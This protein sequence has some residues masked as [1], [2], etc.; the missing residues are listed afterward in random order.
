S[1]RV[2]RERIGRLASGLAELGV[3]PGD[4]V[5]VLDWD[6]HRYLEC[7]FAVPMLGA[8]LHTVNIRLA[9]SQMVYTMNHAEDTVVLVHE[10]FLP[11]VEGMKDDLKTVR[12]WVLLK[13]GDAVPDT[14]VPINVEYE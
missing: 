13:D 12:K 2:F 11:V 8:V 5:A 3:R 9:P 4:V 1:Y 6:S 10:D 14:S 7:Y